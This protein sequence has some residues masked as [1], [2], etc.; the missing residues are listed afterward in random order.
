MAEAA[1]PAGKRKSLEP[2]TAGVDKIRACSAAFGHL[3]TNQNMLL[4]KT[5][6]A[7]VK[8]FVYSTKGQNK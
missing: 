3:L 8:L 6:G 1:F 7:K 4:G 5:R 2:T